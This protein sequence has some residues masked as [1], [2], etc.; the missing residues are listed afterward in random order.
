MLVLAVGA[1]LT[2]LSVHL[3]VVVDVNDFSSSGRDVAVAL[4]LNAGMTGRGIGG[5][6]FFW[7]L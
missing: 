7:H 4:N 5:W 3:R 2:F 6:F 1:D